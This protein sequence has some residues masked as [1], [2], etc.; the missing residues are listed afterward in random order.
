MASIYIIDD[1][2]SICQTIQM[3]L[4]RNGHQ[5][6]ASYYLSDAIEHIRHNPVDVVFLDV[7]LPDGNGLYA[8]TEFRNINPPPDI[9][10]ITGEG[11]PDGAELAI[12]SGAWDYIEKPFSLEELS[13]SLSRVLDYRK[14]KL[15]HKQSHVFKRDHIIGNSPEIKQCIE[16]ASHAALSDVNVIITGETGTGKELFAKAIH[17]NSS[18][19]NNPF[20]VVDCA[21]LPDTLVENILFGH[22]KGAFTGAD[23]RHQGLIQLAHQGTLFLDEVGEL[24]LP[25]Q[26]SF[27]RVLQERK[28]RMVGGTKEIE[29]NFRL[30]AATNRHLDDMCTEGQ[31]RSDLLFRIRSFVID[32]PPLRHRTGDML[33]VASHIISTLCKQ[34]KPKELSSE[35][36]QALDAYDWPGNIRELMNTIERAISLCGN[37]PMLLPIHLPANIRVNIARASLGKQV[38]DSHKT[39]NLDQALEY[40]I[41]P[42]KSVIA[43]TE[44]NYLINLVQYTEGNISDMCKISGLSRS[45]VY[46]RLKKYQISKNE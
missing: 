4:E 43:D 35:F 2:A 42:L 46:E 30:I 26:K 41:P 31:F 21:S 11:D 10:I 34:T 44:K 32:L 40:Y 28:F 37:Q 20:I 19:S 16:T 8:I 24:P 29:S 1:D 36:V 6:S 38:G 12:R 27:L 3:V 25:V 5:V 18:R 15:K 45:R 39:D 14:E 33:V 23:K 13:L 22:E 17:D 9:I 7:R